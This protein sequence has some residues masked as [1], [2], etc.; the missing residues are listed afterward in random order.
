[1]I[2]KD[3]FRKL[4]PVDSEKA[5]KL[6]QYYIYSFGKERN[7][8]DEILDIIL[9]K[10]IGK[11]FKKKILLAPPNSALC[12]GEYPIGI[13]SYPNKELLL[14]L[15]ENEWCRHLLIT[16]MSGTGKTNTVFLIINSLTNK[17]KPFLIFDW[18]QNY[19]DLIQFKKFKQTLIFTAGK[20]TSPFRFNPLVPPKGIDPTQWL[21][22]IIDIIKH[23]YFVGEGVEYLLRKAIHHYYEKFEV[24]EG[25]NA[26][27]T[28]LHIYT[29]IKKMQLTGRMSL[30]KASTMRVLDSLTFPRSM[31]KIVNSENNS[32][33]NHILD[34]MAILEL[35]ALAEVDKIFLTEALIMWIYEKRK[36]ENNRE[37]FKH[38]IIIEEGHHILNEKKEYQEGVETIMET[39]LRQIREFGESVIVIDQEPSKLSNSIKANTNV[40]ITFNLGNGKD[41]KDISEAM[42]LNEEE[43]SYIDLLKVGSAVVKFKQRFHNPIHVKFPLFKINKGLI[44]DRDITE[45][46]KLV[47]RVYP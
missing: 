28:F 33:L 21:L 10:D 7:E 14:G 2:H 40:K 27:P 17:K 44:T 47:Y 4:H 42:M 34:N 43:T 46:M 38:A 11:D 22:K 25:S 19:R 5:E 12:N 32:H 39:A 31:G 1:M 8:Q 29:Y 15:R 13:V 35:D 20:D 26:Y 18:K 36:L 6:W 24:Y 45:H 9:S 3:K 41:I 37:E 23:A 16:G 30:W